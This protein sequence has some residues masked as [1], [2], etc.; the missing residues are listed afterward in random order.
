MLA[1][2]LTIRLGELCNEALIVKTS[3]DSPAAPGPHA[4]LPPSPRANTPKLNVVKVPVN[5]TEPHAAWFAVV[6]DELGFAALL[7]IC[8]AVTTKLAL[9]DNFVI[10]TPAVNK[11]NSVVNPSVVLP[12]GV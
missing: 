9:P 11:S 10:V 8:V 5:R 4:A 3:P 7:L 1:V 2:L 12:P 6:Q